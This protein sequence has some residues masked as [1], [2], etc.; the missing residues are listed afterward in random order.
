MKRI[1]LVRTAGPR[2]AGSVVRLAANF[3]P[4]EVV[5]VRPEKPSI[6]VHPDFEQM[7]HG[8]PDAARRVRVVGS[9]AEALADCTASVGFTARARDHRELVDWRAARGEL[10]A[11]GADPAE[12]LALVFGNE[13]S[14]LSIEETDPLGTLVRIP[15]SDEH[16]SL[17]LAMAAGVVLS[18]LFL[19]QPEVK[20]AA[21]QNAVPLPGS[22]RVFLV[23]RLK[24]ALGAIPWTDSA[25]RD[26]LASIERVFA[27]APLETRDARA[28]HMLAR[29]LGNEKTPGEYGVAMRAD[30]ADAPEESR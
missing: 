24:E 6:L 27:R 13:E 4:C 29:A 2:N 22:D 17:N 26:L 28:W 11:V 3:G 21:R 30:A 5:L 20:S 15:T 10:A 1:V 19:E 7:A 18:A 8:V 25:R 9:V 16:G 23:E 14:G 12:R